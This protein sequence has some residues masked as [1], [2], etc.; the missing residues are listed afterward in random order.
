MPHPLSLKLAGS[1]T[2]ASQAKSCSH[3]YVSSQWSNTLSSHCSK[4]TISSIWPDLSAELV[5]GH[6]HSCSR[7]GRAGGLAPKGTPHPAASHRAAGLGQAQ[8]LRHRLHH[9]LRALRA[10]PHLQASA[11]LSAYTARNYLCPVKLH[12]CRTGVCPA[13]EPHAAVDT[14][15]SVPPSHSC[16]TAFSPCC[17][18]SW[19]GANTVWCTWQMRTREGCTGS[20]TSCRLYRANASSG[21]RAMASAPVDCMLYCC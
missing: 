9:K 18:L 5:G 3:G 14:T 12:S 10:A 21:V 8:H 16:N 2:S 19:Y 11:A 13:S 4:C 6:S 17:T 1:S 7:Q 15:A 20:S